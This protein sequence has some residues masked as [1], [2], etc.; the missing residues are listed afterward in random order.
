MQFL[1]CS[2]HLQGN[3]NFKQGNIKEAENF[4]KKAISCLKHLQMKV[5]RKTSFNSLNFILS[6]YKYEQNLTI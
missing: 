1:Q 4:Y 3:T 6:N 5:L 2:F